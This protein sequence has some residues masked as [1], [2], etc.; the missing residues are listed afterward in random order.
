[1]AFTFLHTADWQL[2]KRF[3]QF[4]AEAAPLLTQARLDVISRIADAARAASAAHILV[5]GDVFE[6]ADP[7]DD[8]V[9]RAVR[10]IES[11]GALTW[12]L[13]AGNHDAVRAG[14]AWTQIESLA[15][16]A[17]IRC[18]TAPGHVAIAPGV[19]LLVA[20]LLH[21]GT[22]T[23]PTQWMDGHGSAPGTIRIGLAHGSVPTGGDPTTPIA[24]DR[25]VRARLD[26]LALGDWHGATRINER[27]W[28]SGTPEPDRFKD[29]APGHVLAV[30]IATPGAIPSVE[31]MPVA[32]HVWRE[33]A[34]IATT[35]ADV[36]ALAQSLVAARGER[37][38]VVK[39]AVSGTVSADD[40]AAIRE[41]AR[42]IEALALCGTVDLADLVPDV[43]SDARFDDTALGPIVAELRDA[44]AQETPDAAIAREALRLIA[45]FAREPQ[46]RSKR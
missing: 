41:H 24:P 17:N 31:L 21:K 28:Y 1:L 40:L 25:A 30:T 8:L 20:P 34:V 13:I 16:S 22:S 15:K 45:E 9:R 43:P 23:D 18:Y 35:A 44:S 4:P 3:G 11:D 19:D 42:D 14:S 32:A 46:G 10:L 5:A 6:A 29:N 36:A 26:Y 27:T 38:L 33:E 12:H 37:K 39:I 7:P 2:G